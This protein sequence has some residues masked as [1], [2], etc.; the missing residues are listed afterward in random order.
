MDP[1]LIKVYQELEA[2]RAELLNLVKQHNE[3]DRNRTV[4]GKWSVNEI[5]SHLA[6]S[7]RLSMAYIRK[8]SNAIETLDDTGL[9]EELKMVLLKISQRGPFRFKAPKIVADHTP[10]HSFKE[11]EEKWNEVR[12]ELLKFIYIMKFLLQCSS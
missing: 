5:L 11:S 2:Q 4:N 8:K 6:T 12:K 10:K 1:Q 9:I 7:E 3:E